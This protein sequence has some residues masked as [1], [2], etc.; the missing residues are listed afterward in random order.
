[1][2]VVCVAIALSIAGANAW[3][4]G[5]VWI[6]IAASELAWWLPEWRG[7][8]R[9]TVDRDTEIAAARTFL[10]AAE[11]GDRF[12][13]EEE[14]FGEHIIQQVT[15]LQNDA[16][17]EVVQ[18]VLRAQFVVGE[19][20]QILHVAFCPPLDYEPQIITHQLDGA[21]V[22]IKVAQAEVFG[23]RLELRL[24]TADRT[25]QS[26]AICFEAEPPSSR[27]PIEAN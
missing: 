17:I 5:S 13:N 27:E 14:E 25:A 7:S 11:D 16:G 18:G 2:C 8:M 23:T 15:R 24:T 6:A 1:M 21:P 3:V 26:V 22:I 19:R 20:T 12:V 9:R 10:E 4:V